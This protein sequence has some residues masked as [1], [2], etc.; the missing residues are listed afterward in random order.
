M[1]TF[2]ELLDDIYLIT[3]RPDLVD[4]T[5][6]ALKTAILKEHSPLGHDLR[7]DLSFITIG[8][9]QA[10]P[11]YYRYQISLGSI[12]GGSRIRKIKSLT[13]MSS[14]GS[15][16]SD[17]YYGTLGIIKFTEVDS[18]NIVDAYSMEIPNY[19]YRSGDGLYLAAARQVDTI[20][21]SAY[22]YP[23]LSNTATYTDWLADLYPYLL[24]ASASAEI[25]RVT[26]K[27]DKRRQQLLDLQD[28]RANLIR[29]EVTEIG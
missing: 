19:F 27:D 23:D 18:D 24:I 9:D 3:S 17:T 29:N 16:I 28:A 15:V 14:Q 6:L 2:S 10:D 22:L 21:L 12:A 4:R 8:L 25:F 5:T 1:T 20:K 13:E 26:G 7:R 11:N